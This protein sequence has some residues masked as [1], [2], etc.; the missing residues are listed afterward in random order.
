MNKII[1][2][3]VLCGVLASPALTVYGTRNFNCHW[4]DMPRVCSLTFE[5]NLTQ[6]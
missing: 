6:R 1:T 5:D 4:R 2:A 3:F